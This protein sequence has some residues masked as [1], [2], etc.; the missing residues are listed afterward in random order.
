MWIAVVWNGIDIIGICTVEPD[1]CLRSLHGIASDDRLCHIVSA[2]GIDGFYIRSRLT[3]WFLTACDYF[4]CICHTGIFCFYIG[5]NSLS[6]L[7]GFSAKSKVLCFLIG[8]CTAFRK[9]IIEL[10][11]YV[12]GLRSDCQIADTNC[13]LIV[14]TRGCSNCQIYPGLCRTLERE[15]KIRCCRIN[16]QNG[17]H[18]FLD[19]G[20]NACIVSQIRKFIDNSHQ[21]SD[22]YFSTRYQ[23]Q[24]RIFQRNFYRCTNNRDLLFDH[25]IGH[26]ESDKSFSVSVNSH[27]H[28][29]RHCICR[30]CRKY[31]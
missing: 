29:Y 7:Y 23:R 11:F 5:C 14:L 17:I 6:I 24:N 27:N 1:L 10:Q 18:N 30:I 12:L 13:R 4:T 20:N 8:Q 28:A 3:K 2:N 26:I 22:L 16:L 25:Y 21:I 9:R 19:C 15:F 31:L